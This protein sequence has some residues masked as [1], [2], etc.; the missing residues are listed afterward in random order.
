[1]IVNKFLDKTDRLCLKNAQLK[2]FVLKK[3]TT[4]HRL[5]V[6]VFR[7]FFL[8]KRRNVWFKGR[9][10]ADVGKDQD[11]WCTRWYEINWTWTGLKVVSKFRIGSVIDCRIDRRTLCEIGPDCCW[12]LAVFRY[13]KR[14]HAGASVLTRWLPLSPP[15]L[16]PSIQPDACGPGSGAA[17]TQP[18]T[19]LGNSFLRYARPPEF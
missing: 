14:T 11:V 4:S 5:G 13:G 17:F 6:R 1:M 7:I 2:I 9:K 18:P 8:W 15:L 12:F 19:S 16:R 10:I 3:G